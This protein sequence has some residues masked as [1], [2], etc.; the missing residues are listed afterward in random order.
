MLYCSELISWSLLRRHPAH[1]PDRAVDGLAAV[2]RQSLELLKELARPLLLIGG[3]VLPGF[4]AVEHA[5][6]L[7]RRQAGEMLQSF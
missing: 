5:F 2:G 6:L 3:Q 1:V 4:H 7:L